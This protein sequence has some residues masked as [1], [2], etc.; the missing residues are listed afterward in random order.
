MTDR[1]TLLDKIRTAGVV[2]AGGAGFPTYKK[3]DAKV[4]CVIANGADEE[5]A[6]QSAQPEQADDHHDQD[7]G[8]VDTH[9][10]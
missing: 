9:E 5:R 3:L 6:D 7:G 10:F 8:D 4:E 2:G 1:S